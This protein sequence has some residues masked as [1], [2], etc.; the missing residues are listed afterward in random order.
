MT[1]HRGDRWFLLSV[2]AP[3]AVTISG[4]TVLWIKTDGARAFTTETAR[5]VAVAREPR[6]PPPVMLETSSRERITLADLRGR[7]LV[8]DF[9]YTNCPTLCVGLGATFTRLQSK[10]V[11]AGRDDVRLVSIGFDTERDTPRALAAYGEQHRADARLWTLARVADPQGL[12][13]LLTSFGV[14]VIADGYGGFTH[15]AAL[16]VVDARGR[17]VRV[18]DAE[19]VEGVLALLSA[20]SAP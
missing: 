17:L 12:R 9:I 8:V 4:T 14:V 19:D 7:A 2:V 5:R 6:V 10:L 13:P 20:G 15:N 1:R 3:V 18:L 16:H 11:E